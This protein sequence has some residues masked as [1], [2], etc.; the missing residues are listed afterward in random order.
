MH[1]CGANPY[2]SSFFDLYNDHLNNSDNIIN[3]G[4]VDINSKLFKSIIEDS[5]FV[6]FPSLS[7]GGCASVITLMGNGGLIPIVSRS[8]CIDV[9]DYGFVFDE[10]TID[11]VEATINKALA[12]DDI[13]LKNMSNKSY[14]ITNI[15]HSQSN[16]VNNLKSFLIKIIDDYKNESRY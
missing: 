1:V 15:K 13:K 9:D 2:E 3:H 7:E 16:Y 5:L 11:N 6:I 10:C 14:S 4:F 8:S 12:Y